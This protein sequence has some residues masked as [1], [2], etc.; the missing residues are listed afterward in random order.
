MF[1]H[2]H[3]SKQ[4]KADELDRFLTGGWFRSGEGMSTSQILNFSGELY[5][6]VRTRLPLKN[7]T[8]RK[9]LLR[10]VKKNHNF[11][12]VCRKSFYTSE[13]EGLYQQFK[14]K[15]QYQVPST[16]RQYLRDDF[17]TSVFETYEVAVFDQDKLIA[18]SFFDLGNNCLASILGVY[19]ETYAKYSLGFYTMLVEIDFGI[20]NKFKYYHPGY[21]VPGYPKFDYKLKIGDL[22]YFHDTKKAWHPYNEMKQDSLPASVIESRIAEMA[23]ELNTHNI[24]NKI[25][26]YPFLDKGFIN[27]IGAQLELSNPLFIQILEKKGHHHLAIE[28]NYYNNKYELASY[29]GFAEPVNSIEYYQFHEVYQSFEG[30]LIKLKL[31]KESK[32]CK[33]IIKALLG[34][35]VFK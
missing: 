25:Y 15:F 18:V 6:P 5:S 17:E 13:K 16:L 4:I 29:Y 19:D 10:I 3:Y 12:T 8:F 28:Y 11:K 20:K 1:T 35:A 30:Y 23:T 2:Y 24:P 27:R 14:V 26:Y 22:E 32:Q 9:S 7:Y 31:L 21:V 34:K 33:T